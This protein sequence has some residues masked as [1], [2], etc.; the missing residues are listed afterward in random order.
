MRWRRKVF[1]IKDLGEMKKTLGIRITGD[2]KNRTVHL[3]QSQY[4]D[5]VLNRHGVTSAHRPNAPM[6]SLESVRPYQEGDDLTDVK[7]YQRTLGEMIYGALTRPDIAQAMRGLCQHMSKPAKH[8]ATSLHTLLKYVRTTI[9]LGITFGATS[10]TTATMYSDADW[11]SDKSDR[12]S[13]SGNV[14]MLFGGPV[15]WSSKK[16]KSV[17]ISSTESEYMSMAQAA[18]QA[19]WITQILKDMGYH[20]HI[21]NNEVFHIKGD[22]QG[23]LALVENPHLHERSKHI[24]ISYHFIRDLQKRGSIETSFIPTADMIADGFTKPLT[25]P[26]FLKFRAMLGMS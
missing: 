8:H 20:E 4:L 23:A 13:I 11:A 6:S 9:D 1:K 3:D 16:Q 7:E 25:G 26:K 21:G 10:D 2:R 14:C 12:K 5:D 18:K 17:A 22:N 19:V 24:D 15:S